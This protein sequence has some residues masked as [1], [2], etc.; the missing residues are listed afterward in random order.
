VPLTRSMALTRMSLTTMP[1]PRSMPLT[2]ARPRL[3]RS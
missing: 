2:T 1:P 3:I